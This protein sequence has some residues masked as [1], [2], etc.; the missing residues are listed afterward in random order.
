MP[1][2]CCCG[3]CECCNAGRQPASVRLTISGVGGGGCCDDWNAEFE[4]Q[5]LA[6][7]DPGYATG[8]GCVNYGLDMTGTP[9]AECY[10]DPRLILNLGDCE[11]RV[12]WS[13]VLWTDFDGD[14]L[15]DAKWR[16]FPGGFFEKIDCAE[17]RELTW[18]VTGAEGTFDCDFESATVTIEPL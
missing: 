17:P 13:L 1:Q 8:F 11:I 9:F 14:T 3:K 16:I 5:R 4:L 2:P 6:P 15:T 18:Y 7:G 12:V 10:P